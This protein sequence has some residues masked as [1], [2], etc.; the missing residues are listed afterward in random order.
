MP[1]GVSSLDEIFIPVNPNNNYWIFIFVRMQVKR[2]ELWDFLGSQ[3]S[4]P[5]YLTAAEKFVKDALARE[6]S[7]GRIT[8]DQSWRFGW[9]SSDRSGD[10]P[11]QGNGYDYGIFMLTSMSLIRN[12]LRLS[13]EAYTQG[14]LTLR[15]ARNRLAERIWAMGVNSE[16]TWWSPQ[17]TPTATNGDAPTA[18]RAPGL[19][20]RPCR[21]KIKNL[22]AD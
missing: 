1:G 6:E 11:R 4:N 13:K 19:R 12:G 8:A 2:M 9:K 17:G 21:R 20:G 14:T 5:K 10:S 15:R 22:K 3:A 16:A 7:A 18:G